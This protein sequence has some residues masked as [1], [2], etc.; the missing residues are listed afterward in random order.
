MD[1]CDKVLRE[2][3]WD[4]LDWMPKDIVHDMS[5]CIDQVVAAMDKCFL[6]ILQVLA[7]SGLL[8]LVGAAGSTDHLVQC[9]EGVHSL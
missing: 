8:C 4:I 7:L 5:K 6:L 1:D 9:H 3:Q 2:S